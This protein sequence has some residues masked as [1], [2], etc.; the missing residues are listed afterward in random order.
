MSNAITLIQFK[1]EARVD[2]R[3]LAK[4]LGNQHKAIMA[5]IE[6][7]IAKFK[8]FGALPFQME[9]PTAGSAGGRPERYALLNEDQ[10]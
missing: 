5:L 9:K 1:G 7:Y 6:R 10:S 2:S 4:R 8:R 3:L